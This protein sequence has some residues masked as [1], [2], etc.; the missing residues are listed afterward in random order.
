MVGLKVEKL[1]TSVSNTAGGEQWR[2]SGLENRATGNGKGSIPSPA[3][4]FASLAQMV[5]AL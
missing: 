5:R 4:R 3:A 1:R 2:S